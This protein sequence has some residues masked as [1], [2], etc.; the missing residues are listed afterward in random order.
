MDQ[1]KLDGLRKRMQEAAADDNQEIGHS[2]ADAVLIELIQ[3]LAVDLPDEAH[4]I[5]REIIAQWHNRS[6]DWWWS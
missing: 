4:D 5:V 1:N 2:D 3:L 6:G